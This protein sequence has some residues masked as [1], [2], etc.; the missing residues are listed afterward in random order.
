MDIIHELRVIAWLEGI[1][2]AK[3]GRPK[4]ANPYDQRTRPYLYRVWLAGHRT[5]IRAE[6]RGMYS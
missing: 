3:M 5:Q 4:A 2:A 1:H 6:R